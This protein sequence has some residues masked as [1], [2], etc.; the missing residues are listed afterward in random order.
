MQKRSA[1]ILWIR[2]PST[3]STTLC[4]RTISASILHRPLP[5]N[6][7]AAPCVRLGNKKRQQ[8]Q[9]LERKN[10]PSQNQ[11][12]SEDSVDA[13]VDART[14]YRVMNMSQAAINV[15]LGTASNE[16]DPDVNYRES[17]QDPIA[18]APSLSTPSVASTAS[19]TPSATPTPIATPTPTESTKNDQVLFKNFFGATKNAI[20]R[21]AQSII[22]NHEKKNAAKQKEQPDHS[23]TVS[24][25]GSPNGGSSV[26]QDLVKSPTDISKKKEFFS[27]LTSSSS[28]RQRLQL[29]RIQLLA[30]LLPRLRRH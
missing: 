10:L 2:H 9:V 1:L 16:I 27:L 14:R 17:H 18:D 29:R 11:I 6:W 8:Q 21:T 19:A 26:P 30:L 5:P 3:K 25:V 23:G 20:F 15:E 28:K 13:G 7:T 22:E 12:E 4:S 24:L